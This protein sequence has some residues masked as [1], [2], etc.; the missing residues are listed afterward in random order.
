MFLQN[1]LFH[2]KV[3]IKQLFIIYCIR[4]RIRNTLER[5]MKTRLTSYDKDGDDNDNDDYINMEKKIIKSIDEHKNFINCSKLN[6]NELK[7]EHAELIEYYGIDDENKVKTRKGRKPKRFRKKNAQNLSTLNPT[8][9][10]N[11]GTALDI[12]IPSV[13]P[14]KHEITTEEYSNPKEDDDDKNPDDDQQNT[15]FATMSSGNFLP[16]DDVKYIFS[17]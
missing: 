1:L 14:T 9:M 16:E 8:P 13:S 2:L 10:Q 6:N 15:I 12:S 4:E 7:K 3:I 11:E 17:Q 5:G